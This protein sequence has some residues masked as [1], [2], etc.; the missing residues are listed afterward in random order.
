[1]L[2]IIMGMIILYLQNRNLTF[3]F[4][5]YIGPLNVLVHQTKMFQLFHQMKNY[6]KFL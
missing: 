3:I 5:F 6:F 1:M 4:I 2:I